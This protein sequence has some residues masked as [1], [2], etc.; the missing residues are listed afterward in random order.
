MTM[1]E[2]IRQRHMVR[3]YLKQPIPEEVAAR[4]QARLEEDN[5]TSGL[6]LTLV[7][8]NS[9]GLGAMAKLISKNVNHYII[10]AGPD[11]P[12]LD[13]KLGYW[14][15]DAMLFAQTL[16]LNSWWVGGMFNAK[17]AAKHLAGTGL[18]INGV[19]VVGYGATQGTPHK[20]KTAAEISS[21]DGAAPRWFQDGVSALLLAPTALNKQAY[22]IRGEGN[23][24]TLTCDS[25]HFAGIDLGI[26]RFH[27][28]TGA[29]KDNFEWAEPF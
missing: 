23:N 2:A 4:L 29:G 5:Q 14:G 10:L 9:D 3:K 21:Y 11:G 1:Q 6:C 25:G 28:E 18:R 13:E 12:D 19:I 20:S 26:G 8:G 17:G 27:F 24:V 7:T 15:A 22:R 16:G